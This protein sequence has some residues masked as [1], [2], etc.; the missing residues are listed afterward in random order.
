MRLRSIPLSAW[1]GI[2]GIAI[3][4]FAAIFADFIA[5]YGEGE[6]VG[7]IW[8]PMG[9]DFLLGTD[10]SGR[11]IAAQIFYGARISLHHDQRRA[12][13]QHFVFLARHDPEFYRRRHRRRG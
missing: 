2:L 12:G 11:D 1:I 13:G 3:A 6:I 4:I 7:D 8:L 10:N 5:P 9:G